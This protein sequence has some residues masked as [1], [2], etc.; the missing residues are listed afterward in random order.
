MKKGVSEYRMSLELGHAPG[1]INTIASGKSFPSFR[2]FLYICEY[3]E[4]TPRDFFDADLKDPQ[5]I[6][7]I[8]Q[9][10][11]KM[12]V[13]DLKLLVDLAKRINCGR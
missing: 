4:I 13:E 3:F 11:Q 5:P 2:E 6:R 7:E 10:A 1:Y 8:Y 12:R 9:E